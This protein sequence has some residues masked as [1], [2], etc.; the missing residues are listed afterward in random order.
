M[1]QSIVIFATEDSSAKV[2]HVQSGDVWITVKFN[3]SD[4]CRYSLSMD[5]AQEVSSSFTI[6]D[7][8]DVIQIGQLKLG[9]KPD[10]VVQVIKDALKE[11]GL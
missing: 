4:D 9:A 5:E 8:H 2:E 11:L 10:G 7:Y 1:Y 6:Y 3:D